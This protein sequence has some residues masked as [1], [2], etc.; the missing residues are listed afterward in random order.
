MVTAMVDSVG[1]AR[2]ASRTE[3][4]K[5][6]KHG[7]RAGAC[8]AGTFLPL[9]IRASVLQTA[10]SLRM[11]ELKPFKSP[12][13]FSSKW[14]VL[15]HAIQ[16]LQN[17]MQLNWLLNSAHMWLHVNTVCAW[18]PGPCLQQPHVNFGSPM[19]LD[20]AAS[21]PLSNLAQQHP[22]HSFKGRMLRWKVP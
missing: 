19:A 6:W 2:R 5:V 16:G 7:M 13:A 17:R 18:N 21:C 4:V 1:I 22:N 15:P 10:K 12:A 3:V 11:A 8:L 14:C 9:M 20:H